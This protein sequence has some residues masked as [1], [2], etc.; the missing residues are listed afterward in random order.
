M[1]TYTV[2]EQPLPQADRAD[3]AEDLRFVKDGFSWLTLIFPPLGFIRAQLWLELGAY[4]VAMTGLMMIFNAIGLG[5]AWSG[6]V[7]MAINAFLAFEMSS[8]QRAAYERRGWTMAGTVSG[9]SLDECERR[10]F[11][12]WLPDQPMIR[13]IDDATRHAA[14]LPPAQSYWRFSRKA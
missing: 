2:H 6:L 3:R 8:L 13:A 7:M 10:F 5:P 9:A 12:N 4:L 1:Q 14:T 11:E